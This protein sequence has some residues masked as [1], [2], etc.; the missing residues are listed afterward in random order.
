[1]GWSGG[2]ARGLLSLLFCLLFALLALVLY[3]SFQSLLLL[4]LRCFACEVVG[5]Y[6]MC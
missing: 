5:D 6:V 3:F 4:A 2:S 1:M